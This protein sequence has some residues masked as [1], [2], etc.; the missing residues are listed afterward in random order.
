VEA[1]RAVAPS[2][3]TFIWCCWALDMTGAEFVC[4]V[5]PG[6]KNPPQNS[7]PAFPESETPEIM[8]A[9]VAHPPVIAPAV[10]VKPLAEAAGV[11]AALTWRLKESNPVVLASR[12]LIQLEPSDRMQA[13]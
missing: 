13:L 7:S 9:S 2:V 3:N 12:N 5:A 11:A 10:F 1:T 6:F 4:P 8:I